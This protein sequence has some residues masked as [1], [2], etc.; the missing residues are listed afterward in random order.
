MYEVRSNISDRRIARVLFVLIGNRM[1]LLHGF[2]KK[3][4]KTPRRDLDLAIGRMK[5]VKIHE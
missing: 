2:I 1:V 5:E 4:Q 3:A